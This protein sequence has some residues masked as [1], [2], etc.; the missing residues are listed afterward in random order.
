MCAL[1]LALS[2]LTL[3]RPNLDSEEFLESKNIL[4]LQWAVLC[5]T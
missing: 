5:V 1:L 3:I 4:S 2:L